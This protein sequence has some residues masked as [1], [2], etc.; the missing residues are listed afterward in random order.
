MRG[1]SWWLCRKG[2]LPLQVGMAHGESSLHA[3]CGEME[4]V[5][6]KEAMKEQVLEPTLRG[7]TTKRDT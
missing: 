7:S 4:E 6:Q 5:C 2:G 3:S 1:K